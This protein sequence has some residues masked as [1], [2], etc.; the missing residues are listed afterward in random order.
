M[1]RHYVIL[2]WPESQDWME[3]PEFENHSYLMNDEKGVEEFGSS[4]Y[5]VDIQW[6]TERQTYWGDVESLVVELIN[7]KTVEVPNALH[8][9]F[10]KACERH[11]ITPDGGALVFDEDKVTGKYFY[12]D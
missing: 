2:A 10:L 12:L 4:T 3:E 7:K 9:D 11:S 1:D 5:F 8:D 6:M